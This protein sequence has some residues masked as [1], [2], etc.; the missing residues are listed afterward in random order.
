MVHFVGQLSKIVTNIL[1]QG[2][3]YF[4]SHIQGFHSVITWPVL[5]VQGRELLLTQPSSKNMEKEERGGVGGGKAEVTYT[6]QG[7][8]LNDLLPPTIPT[9]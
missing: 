9:S 8:I 4:D 3:I 6:L 5:L 2:E 1:G 7:Y